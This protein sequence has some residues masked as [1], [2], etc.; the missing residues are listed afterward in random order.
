MPRATSH[1]FHVWKSD[2]RSATRSKKA[3]LLRMPLSRFVVTVSVA[4]QTAILTGAVWIP[5]FGVICVIGPLT[6]DFPLRS[7]GELDIGYVE[8]PSAFVAV[9]C[10]IGVKPAT[11][12]RIGAGFGKLVAADVRQGRQSLRLACDVGSRI[13]TG[14]SVQLPEEGELNRSRPTGTPAVISAVISLARELGVHRV[15]PVRYRIWN[16]FADLGKNSG[17]TAA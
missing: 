6:L 16:Y 3:A 14:I 1:G 4:V 12:A 8:G 10:A 13:A 9:F 7:V 5:G 2:A 11:A 17:G 15:I